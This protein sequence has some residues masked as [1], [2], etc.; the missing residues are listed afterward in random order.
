[1]YKMKLKRNA[2]IGIVVIIAI[3]TIAVIALLHPNF[4]SGLGLSKTITN[5]AP[6]GSS[7]P[8]RFSGMRGGFVPG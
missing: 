3:L 1:M 2:I 7:S 5:S 6:I 4:A 8:Q